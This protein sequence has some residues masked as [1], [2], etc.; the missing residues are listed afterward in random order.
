M[1]W[2]VLTLTYQKFQKLSVILI[3]FSK[4]K[5]GI[6]NEIKTGFGEIYKALKVE[7]ADKKKLN[8]HVQMTDQ[9]ITYITEEKEIKDAAMLL[10]T[11]PHFKQL[12][13][14]PFSFRF[15]PIKL[16][17]T[18]QLMQNTDKCKMSPSSGRQEFQ[19]HKITISVCLLPLHLVLIFHLQHFISS[20]SPHWPCKSQINFLLKCLTTDCCWKHRDCIAAMVWTLSKSFGNGAAGRGKEKVRSNSDKTI[21]GSIGQVIYWRDCTSSEISWKQY[22]DICCNLYSIQYLSSA[23]P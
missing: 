18:L 3:T 20:F 16:P 11:I 2:K 21:L 10:Y 22:T 14:T 5:W 13:I 15:S 7:Q 17:L 6:Y 1:Y 4:N 12:V 8:T 19:F 23:G 9:A